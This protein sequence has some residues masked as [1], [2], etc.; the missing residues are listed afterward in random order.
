MTS[1]AGIDGLLGH[2]VGRMTRCPA[3]QPIEQFLMA[4][5]VDAISTIG[6]GSSLWQ[7]RN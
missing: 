2:S 3:C 7:R 6:L 5:A 1:G 4:L